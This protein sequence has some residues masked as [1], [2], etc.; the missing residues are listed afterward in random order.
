STIQDKS[1]YESPHQLTTG[2]EYVFVNGRL[3][4]DKG[5]HTGTK[6]GVALRNIQ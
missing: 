5:Q 4:I 6:T 3:V 1:I 2:I